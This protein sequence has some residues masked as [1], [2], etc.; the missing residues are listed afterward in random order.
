MD[1]VEL[2]REFVK[3]IE[4]LEA[5]CRSSE[6]LNESLRAVAEDLREQLRAARDALFTENGKLQQAIGQVER[7]TND[8]QELLNRLAKLGGTEPTRV[9]P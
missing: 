3:R 8:K 7:L 1:V 9:Q 5:N 4:Q 6:A 2:S